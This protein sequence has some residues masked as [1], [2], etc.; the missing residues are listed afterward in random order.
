[1]YPHR[2]RLRGPWHCE[3]LERFGAGEVPPLCRL[4]VP[5]RWK[6][7]GLGDFAGR[8]RFRRRFGKPARL[9][10]FERV[11]LTFAGVDGRAI[12]SLNGQ[13][14]GSCEGTNGTFEHDVTALLQERNEL[15]VEIHSADGNGG[16][17]GEVTLLVRCTAW[18]A[19]VRCEKGRVSGK[20]V[21]SADRPL[22]LYILV[23]G[24]TIF[25]TLARPTPQGERFET[26]L[27]PDKGAASEV[28]IELVNGAVVWDRVV[29]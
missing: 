6:D 2:I 20:V 14:I 23:N 21:G 27:P 16:L 1:M 3:A 29:V 13:E 28:T 10:A 5:G 8:V 15:A 24:A 26:A 17:W 22:D 12:F 9:D 7:A 18:L 11:W 19:E 4:E 25:Y